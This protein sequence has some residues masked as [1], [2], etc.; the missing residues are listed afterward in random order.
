MVPW[1]KLPGAQ[2]LTVAVSILRMSMSH[3]SCMAVFATELGVTFVWPRCI[4]CGLGDLRRDVRGTKFWKRW[5]AWRAGAMPWLLPQKKRNR[6]DQGANS[7]ESKLD[8]SATPCRRWIHQFVPHTSQRKFPSPC[9][10]Y[11]G[12]M[13]IT[14]GLV[15]NPAKPRERGMCVSTMLTATVSAFAPRNLLFNAL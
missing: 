7:G 4:T 2:A 8:D 13:K 12:Q 5:V 15:E 1:S 3:C 14:C 11:L 10:I 6:S 9:A